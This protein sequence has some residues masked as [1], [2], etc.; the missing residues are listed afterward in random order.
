MNRKAMLQVISAGMLWGAINL[1]IK[2][3]SAAGLTSLQI[4][5][6]RMVVASVGFG[7]YTLLRNP[8]AFRI[9]LKDIWMFIGTGMVSVVL[10]NTC[11]FYTIIH[12]QASVAVVLLYTSP[13][14][15]LLLSALLFGERIT[16]RKLLAIGL[17]LLG[18]VL[19]SGLLTGSLTVPFRVLVT[20]IL[21][22]FL[23]GLYTIFGRYALQ[24]YSSATVTA[25]TFLLAAVCSLCFTDKTGVL[26][27]LTASPANLLLCLGLGLFS[28]ILPYYLY[29]LGL[30]KLE[31][32]VAA[33]L[34]AVEPAVGAVLGMTVFH[35]DRGALKLLGIVLVL[36]AIV[37]MNRD[38]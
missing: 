8:A 4:A 32:G 31:S 33:V 2:P 15:I 18:C 27:V 5:M 12:G 3:L 7:G 25:Y 26:S 11:Y 22:G 17:T 24:K 13:V 19:V 20:G 38:E 29:T 34:V 9:C 21:S 23:Y 10:F 14:F 28:T 36:V 1:F 37:V 6:A 16:R 35:E 30:E